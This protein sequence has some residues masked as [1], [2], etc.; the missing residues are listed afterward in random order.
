MVAS[1]LGNPFYLMKTRLQA[2]HSAAPLKGRY[3][4]TCGREGFRHIY[5]T[6]GPFGFFRG[7]GGAMPRVSLGSAAQIVS[8]DYVKKHL[9]RTGLVDEGLALH[10]ASSLI[11]GVFCVTSMNPF[12]VV[13]VRL[14]NQPLKDGVVGVLYSGPIDCIQKIVRE[15]GLLA[16][17]KGWVAQYFRLGPHVRRSD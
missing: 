17:Q 15:E 11:A 4:Y 14:Y 9:V 3:Q 2:A 13:S 7:L 12:D 8:Y 1:I 6:D 16:L 5:R 10:F